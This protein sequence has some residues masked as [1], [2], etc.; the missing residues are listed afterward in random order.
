M[1]GYVDVLDV[2][3]NEFHKECAT[4]KLDLEA[5]GIKYEGKIYAIDFQTFNIRFVRHIFSI[6]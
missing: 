3:I 1:K 5:F 4:K 6:K 2:A